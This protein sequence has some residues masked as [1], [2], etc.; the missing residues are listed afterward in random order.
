MRTVRIG[1][2][3]GPLSGGDESELELARIMKCP[4]R[5]VLEFRVGRDSSESVR[6][7]VRNARR[8][9]HTPPNASRDYVSELEWIS[10]ADGFVY[11]TDTRRPR[12]PRRNEYYAIYDVA[13][14]AKG[15]D[16]RSRPRVHQL[17]FLDQPGAVPA[18]ECRAA[19][20]D[21]DPGIPIFESRFQGSVGIAEPVLAVVEM[22]VGRRVE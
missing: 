6:V 3:G 11:L 9:Q 21:E 12:W 1:Y 10:A 20:Q 19:L 13:L 2:L 14:A 17:T 5:P 18:A 4:L 15:S 16:W 8:M 7:R 22:V